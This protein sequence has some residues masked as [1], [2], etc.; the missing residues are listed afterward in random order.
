MNIYLVNI[1]SKINL[2][3]LNK[4]EINTNTKKIIYSNEGIY[5]F[6]NDHFNKIVITDDKYIKINISN[7]ELLCD[8]SKNNE[9]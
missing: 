5:N 2:K 8:F 9:I 1:P 6:Q 7:T 3:Q 4:Y